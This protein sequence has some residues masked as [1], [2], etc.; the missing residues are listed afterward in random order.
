MTD[1]ATQETPSKAE[2]I[3]PNER[4]TS[5]VIPAL[6]VSKKAESLEVLDMDG[7]KHTF[8]SLYSGPDTPSRVLVVFVRHVFCGVCMVLQSC[9]P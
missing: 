9:S 7:K 3:A 4:P 6:D 1:T 5:D 2:V 8:A